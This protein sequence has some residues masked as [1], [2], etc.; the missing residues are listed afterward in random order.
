M[1]KEKIILKLIVF[2]TILSFINCQDLLKITLKHRET[3]ERIFVDSA[4]RERLFHGVNAVVKGPP[5]IPETKVFNVYSSLT[6]EDY[7]LLK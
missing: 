7:V 2:L 3:G 6:D 4:G 5:W 1:K